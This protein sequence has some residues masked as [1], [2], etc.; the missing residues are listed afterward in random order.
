MS[1]NSLEN[2]HIIIT[3][4]HEMKIQDYYL[5]EK[6]KQST[7]IDD[8]T[9]EFSGDQTIIRERARSINDRFYTITEIKCGQEE[10]PHR[11]VFK[12]HDIISHSV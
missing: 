5:T 4:E 8:K 7:L 10:I 12:I 1:E 6:I 11:Y 3:M 9:S 2:H